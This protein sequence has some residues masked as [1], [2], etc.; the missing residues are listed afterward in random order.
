MSDPS[1][2]PDDSVPE[3]QSL[4]NRIAEL[5]HANATLEAMAGPYRDLIEH[6]RDMIWTVDMAGS[7]NFLNS[8]C[9]TIT[10]YTKDELLGLG[11]ADII[12]PEDRET[13]Y[14]SMTRRWDGDRMRHYEIRILAKNGQAVDLEVSSALL[15]RTDVPAGILAIGRDITARKQAQEAL[16]R[17]AENFEYLF[18][19][20]PMPMWVIDTKSLQFLEVNQAAMERYGYSR[21]QFLAMSSAALRPPGEAERYRNYIRDLQPGGHGDAGHWQHLAKNGR[22]FDTEVFWRSLNF[23][24]RDAVLAVITDITERKALEEQLRQSHKLEAVGRLAGGVAHEFNNLLTVILGYSQLLLNHLDHE[25]PMHAGLDQIRGSA[26]KAGILTRQLMAFSRR[27]SL[28]PGILDLNKVVAGMEKTLVRLIGD[29]IQLVTKLRPDLGLARADPTEI[30][31]ALMNLALNAR[32]AMPQGGTLTFE[33]ANV[34]FSNPEEAAGHRPGAYAMVAVTDTGEG[35]DT[36]T[37]SR[38]FEPFFSTR[39]K[40]AGGGLG[41]AFV[42]GMIEQHGGFVRVSSELGR[43]SRFEVY[44]PNIPD[45]TDVSVHE[46]TEV[47]GRE[48][49]LVVESKAGVRKL[50]AEAL[51]SCGYTVLESASSAEAL[52]LAKKEQPAVDLLLTDSALPGSNGQELAEAWKRLRPNSK[53]V[54]MFDAAGGEEPCGPERLLPKPFSSVKLAQTIREALDG[55]VR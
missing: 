45:P 3:I 17:S 9:E 55:R 22:I 33:T 16:R 53:M 7:V 14:E 50:I 37:Q 24:G 52:E 25:H 8:A 29:E 39:G 11:L 34:D 18:S 26:E 12:A 19:N 10:G 15:K 23:G 48:T 54:F 49:I 6:A 42:Y 30:E 35:I 27:Q 44:L 32:D 1:R 36:E 40:R 20:H 4:R 51:R 13:A 5:E 47:R 2:I 46:S 41:L 38:L 43:G 28:Q 31:Q 21:E